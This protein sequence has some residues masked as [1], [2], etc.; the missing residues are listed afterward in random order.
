MGGGVTATPLFY[1]KKENVMEYSKPRTL[2]EW[3]QFYEEKS[4]EKLEV[5]KGFLF[6][7]MPTRGFSVMKPDMQGKILMIYSTC[8]DGKFWR[9]V[10]EMLALN[11]G[12]TKLM[13]ICIR[14][15]EPYIR[16]WHWKITKV[17]D[18]NGQKRYFCIDELGRNVL[19]THRGVNKN[20]GQP[21]Y[22]VTQYLIQGEGPTF[23]EKSGD[24]H[25]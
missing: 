19:I 9:D 3:V 13:T 10:G 8:G 4:G 12:M 6:H 7:W 5:P 1:G 14:K 21:T 23:I 24:K 25:V 22:S 17:Q 16:F 20:T 15:I 11:N 2:E 18:V